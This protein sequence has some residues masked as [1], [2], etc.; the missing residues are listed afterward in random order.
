MLRKQTTKSEILSECRRI[1]E[2]LETPEGRWGVFVGESPTQLEYWIVYVERWNPQLSISVTFQF[3]VH[4]GQWEGWS[5]E[6][7]EFFLQGKLTES[8]EALVRWSRSESVV[9]EGGM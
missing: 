2:S 4:D 8:I 9:P 7:R 3:G 1:L 6:E 5:K